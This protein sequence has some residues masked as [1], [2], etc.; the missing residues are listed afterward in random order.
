MQIKTVETKPFDDQKPGT[1]GLRKPVQQ[2]RSPAY[3]EN[4]VQAV[5]DTVPALK[6]HRLVLGGDGRY[7]N[8]EAADT[9]IRMAIANGVSEIIVGAGVLLSTPAAAH[10][11]ARESA[12]GGFLL[13]ASHNPGGPDGDFGIK[14]N[15]EGGGQAP[16]ELTDRIFTRTR[17]L[18]QYRITDTALPSL[19]TPNEHRLGDTR[20]RIVDPVQA[21][22]D[23][24]EAQF[25]FGV[26]R[27]W[28]AERPGRF[29]FDAMHAVTGPY[30]REIFANRLGLADDGILNAVPREDFGGRHPDPNPVDAADFIR[31]FDGPDAP[32]LGGAS[33]GDGDR[34]MIVGPNRVVSPCDSLAVIAAN[35]AVIPAFRDGLPG[36][37]R[38][39][40]TSRAVDAVADDLGIPCY[41]TPT[42]WRFFASLLETGRIRLCGEESFGTSSDHV[43]EKDGLWA[44]LA[45][46][47]ILASRRQSVDG[48]LNEHWQRFGRHYFVR[49]DYQ[50]GADQGDQ[51]MARLA[52]LANEGGLT[53]GDERL[54]LDRF[55]YTDPVSG[56]TVTNQG[57]RLYTPSGG[58]IVFRLSGT[59][60]HGATLRIYLEQYVSAEG[61]TDQPRDRVLQPL[62][63]MAV[64]V[65]G[66]TAVRKHPDPDAVI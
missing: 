40:P 31:Q 65:S 9:V 49:H 38:S 1:A 27:D 58:R 21:H 56:H 7:F 2:F 22:A 66:L 5:F 47:Q 57:I 48:I 28:L 3:L 51:V 63:D 44:V 46:L 13:T 60:T 62:A 15:V 8:R 16:A 53:R 12:A 50:L 64:A 20:L 54:T 37:A 10:L 17:E 33:D 36:V 24:L 61:D 35:H 6:G 41:E 59:G 32:E 34:N 30:A 11:I 52:G 55:D 25:D 4:F 14:F 45:W 42:G 26:I 29:R 43:R 23:L 18:R 39:M 19:D